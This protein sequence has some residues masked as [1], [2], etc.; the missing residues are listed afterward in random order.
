[1]IEKGLIVALVA[2]AIVFAADEIG[3]KMRVKMET[4]DCQ[5]QN[6]QL[7]IHHGDHQ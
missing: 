3:D 4:I 5:L 6:A 7:C 1:M 2:I